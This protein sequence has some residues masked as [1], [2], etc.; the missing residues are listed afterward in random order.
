[1]RGGIDRC[2]LPSVTRFMADFARLPIRERGRVPALT[3]GLYVPEPE[4]MPAALMAE[5]RIQQPK[6][7]P[8]GDLLVYG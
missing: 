1:M 6:P 3:G 8:S 2:Q 4:A 5:A 7:V